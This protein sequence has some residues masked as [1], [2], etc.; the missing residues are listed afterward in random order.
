MKFVAVPDNCFRNIDRDNDY[1]IQIDIFFHNKHGI[2]FIRYHKVLS[3]DFA[4][5]G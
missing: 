1:F 4:K 2:I 5:A 3:L